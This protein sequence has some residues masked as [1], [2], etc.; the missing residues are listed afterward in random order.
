MRFFDPIF[1]QYMPWILFLNTQ[2]SLLR[3]AANPTPQ[4]LTFG[5]PLNSRLLVVVVAVVV[6]VFAVVVVVVEVVAGPVDTV[7]VVAV[8]SCGWWLV[9][10]CVRGVRWNARVSTMTSRRCR[11]QRRR[12]MIT[13]GN[14]KFVPRDHPLLQGIQKSTSSSPQAAT[15]FFKIPCQGLTS[16]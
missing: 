14:P 6:V 9:A 1:I 15:V 3:E 10:L 4:L 12:H 2:S 11:S 7:V 13:L 5:S 8:R 16:V